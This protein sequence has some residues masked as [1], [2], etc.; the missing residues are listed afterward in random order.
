MGIFS[1]IFGFIPLLITQSFGGDLDV[2]FVFCINSTK[3]VNFFFCSGL[4]VCVVL[5]H[6]PGLSVVSTFLGDDLT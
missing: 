1:Q 4:C 6:S 3:G 5:G 2:T